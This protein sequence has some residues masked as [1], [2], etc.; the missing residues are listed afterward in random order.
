MMNSV[1]SIISFEKKTTYRNKVSIYV[2]KY[3]DKKFL[4]QKVTE[5]FTD[6]SYVL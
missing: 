1:H 4:R 3:T 5:I 6:E 2:F